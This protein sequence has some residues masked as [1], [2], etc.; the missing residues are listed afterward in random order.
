M[1]E[2]GVGLLGFGTIGAGVVKLM[3]QNASLIEEKLGTRLRLRKVADRDITTDR[4]VVVEPGVLTQNV[5]EVPFRPQDIRDHR[6]DWR[7]YC[8]KGIHSEGH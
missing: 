8:C 6:A 3:G 7:V 2:I 1:K 4:G 5:D